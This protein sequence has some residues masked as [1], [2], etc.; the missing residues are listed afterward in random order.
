MISE[1]VV[2]VSETA[3]A[4]HQLRVAMGVL[5]GCINR[6]GPGRR[7]SFAEVAVIVAAVSVPAALAV[8][9]A[10]SAP[11]V[12]AAT[13][14]SARFA[15]RRETLQQLK[16]SCGRRDQRFSCGSSCTSWRWWRSLIVDIHWNIRVL[17]VAAAVSSA[18]I[19]R[20]VSIAA[21]WQWIVVVDRASRTR[22]PNLLHKLRVVNKGVT[23]ALPRVDDR[24]AGALAWGHRRFAVPPL[25]IRQVAEFSFARPRTRTCGWA[26]DELKIR[27][28]T[29]P[30]VP[31]CH[32]KHGPRDR[33][34][35]NRRGLP[36]GACALRVAAR[37]ERSAVFKVVR[38]SGAVTRCVRGHQVV[39]IRVPVL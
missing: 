6:R 5:L 34:F 32:V 10:R 26:V 39:A 37:H 20:V 23:V 22:P 18:V 8:A 14:G 36:G 29:G 27:R 21:A 25:Q 17:V 4:V 15:A 2:P 38:G 28:V 1:L 13:K 35:G 16:V 3:V 12:A 31:R 7:S 9:L 19:V 33:T 24:V 30:L 11:G